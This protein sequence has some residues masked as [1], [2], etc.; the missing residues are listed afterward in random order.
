MI[1]NMLRAICI[2]VRQRVRV[3]TIYIILPSSDI[4]K[5]V[6]CCKNEIMQTRRDQTLFVIVEKLSLIQ[7]LK[8]MH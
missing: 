8:K 2:I 3:T 5:C 4:I 7:P 1:V 6:N